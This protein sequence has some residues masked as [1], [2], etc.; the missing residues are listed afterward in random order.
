MFVGFSLQLKSG[1]TTAKM[2]AADVLR[3][4]KKAVGRPR[5]VDKSIA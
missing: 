2:A 5:S 3:P 4:K 1:R